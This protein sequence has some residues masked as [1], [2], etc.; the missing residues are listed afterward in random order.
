MQALL[1]EFNPWWADPGARVALRRIRREAVRRVLEGLRSSTDR[2]ATLVVGPRQ[3]GKSE[4]LRQVADDLLDEGVHPSNLVYF[5]FDDERLVTNPTTAREIADVRPPGF[6]EHLPKVLLLD[7]ICES[8]GWAKW[9]KQAVD[10]SSHR[11]VA[12]DSAASL[13]RR[14]TL[15][16]GLGR[17]DELPMEGLSFAEFASIAREDSTTPLEELLRAF[18]TALDSFLH[19]GG[20]PEHVHSDSLSDVRRRLRQDI[21]SRAIAK[22]LAK[23][24]V[25][26][27][28]LEKLFVYLVQFSG[29]TV[30]KKHVSDDLQTDGRTV[31]KYLDLLIDARLLVPLEARVTDGPSGR[32]KAGR[33]LK[34]NRKIYAVDHGLVTAFAPVASPLEDAD[35]RGSIWETLVFK[36]VRD[37]AHRLGLGAPTYL[38][39]EEKQEIDFVLEFGEGPIAIEVTSSAPKPRKQAG[40]L[41]SATRIGAV[42]ALLVHGGV[43]LEARDGIVSIP[44]QDFLIDPAAWIQ[45]E[46]P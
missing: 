1:Q 8:E 19:R 30:V 46:R 20:F 31:D 9:L 28:Q 36:H 34:G 2:R 44:L 32:G 13:L 29:S 33:R 39:L 21:V 10:R 18:P 7:E 38:R 17:W 3:V 6:D 41:E 11:I 45:G 14:G 40:L 27:A 23:E 12:T 15:E 25:V 24:G 43:A 42:R 22:D 4:L 26:V 37:T 35:Y 5:D 16:S